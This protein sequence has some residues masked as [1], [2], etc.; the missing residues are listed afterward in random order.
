MSL[1]SL[2]VALIVICLLAWAGKTIM[3]IFALDVR[4]RG[5]ITVLFVVF[6]VLFLIQ[7]FLG[8]GPFLGPIR[9]R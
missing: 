6:I 4:I 8:G 3:D 5:V 1:V 9:I 2:F 7:T